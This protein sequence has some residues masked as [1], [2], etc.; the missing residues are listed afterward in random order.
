MASMIRISSTHVGSLVR[1]DELIAH[2]RRIDAGEPCDED[3]YAACLRDS[4]H[5]VVREQRDVGIDIVSDGEFGKS[6][7]NYYVYR[8]LAGFEI[9]PAPATSMRSDERFRQDDPTIPTDWAR[10]PDFYAEY[11]ANE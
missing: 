7:W 11:F 6:S 10:F 3:A 1:P 9:R 5:E 4:V 8:R 2:L